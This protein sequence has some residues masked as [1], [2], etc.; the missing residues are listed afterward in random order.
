[1]KKT[2]IF[3]KNAKK[4]LCFRVVKTLRTTLRATGRFDRMMDD[5]IIFLGSAYALRDSGVTCLPA[6]C[7]A[8]AVAAP[9]GSM[10]VSAVQA[11]GLV[12]ESMR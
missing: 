11:K 12:W 3:W 7:R 5:R 6:R 10:A 9:Q 2:D 1:M 8:V 4:G